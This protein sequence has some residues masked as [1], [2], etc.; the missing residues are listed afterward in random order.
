MVV[1]SLN[2]ITVRCVLERELGTAEQFPKS[3]PA[4]RFGARARCPRT[5]FDGH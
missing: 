5:I 2:T 1:A 4:F 3:K